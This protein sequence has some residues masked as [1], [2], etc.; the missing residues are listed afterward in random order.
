[1]VDAVADTG[2][3]GAMHHIAFFAGT[4]A[5]TGIAPGSGLAVMRA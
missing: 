4:P 1:M 3:A 5:P 2:V